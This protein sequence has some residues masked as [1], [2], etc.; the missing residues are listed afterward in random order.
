MVTREELNTH[1]KKVRE[2]ILNMIILYI[3]EHGYPP[4]FRE[5]GAGVGLQ[6]TSSVKSHIDK[7]IVAGMLETDAEER[8]APR[9]LRVPGYKFVKESGEEKV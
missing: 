5:I 6:S 1:G 4:S 7:M 8:N 9:A 3:Q 2:R